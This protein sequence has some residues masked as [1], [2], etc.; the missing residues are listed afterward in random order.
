MRPLRLQRNHSTT[1]TYFKSQN[2][3]EFHFSE[4]NF[5]VRY[6]S[7]EILAPFFFDV[8]LSFLWLEGGNYESRR[9]HLIFL[10]HLTK[11]FCSSALSHWMPNVPRRR[12]L[13][14]TEHPRLRH[15]YAEVKA[16][17]NPITKMCERISCAIALGIPYVIR[18]AGE[19][20]M[21]TRN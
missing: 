7:L 10:A 8:L 1:A 12:L 21:D 16:K 9:K 6:N 4:T 18:D 20:K 5:K 15:V 2:E 17:R 14:C 19:S 3:H 13:L 11:R